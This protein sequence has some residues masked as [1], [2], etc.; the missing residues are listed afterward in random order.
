MMVVVEDILSFEKVIL[1]NQLGGNGWLLRLSM[2]EFIHVM[3][4][5]FM[6]YRRLH[7]YLLL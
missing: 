5:I 3:D 6:K 7:F 4:Y 1:V 2:D